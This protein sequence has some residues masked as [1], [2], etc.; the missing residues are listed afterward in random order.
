MTPE[1]CLDR[2]IRGRWAV[3]VHSQGT[4]SDSDSGA[5]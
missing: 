5:A 2:Q 1:V 4:Y 3:S